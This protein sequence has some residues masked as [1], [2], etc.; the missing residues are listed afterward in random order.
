MEGWIKLHRQLL[1][2]PLWSCEVFSRGQAWV[3]L[4]MLANFERSFFYK[5]GVKIEVD[6]GQV[7]RSEV[8]LA[9]R[10]R[11][12]RTKVRSFL[13]DLEKEQ[14]I[15]QQKTN[16]TQIVE[17]INYEYYQQEKQQTGQQKNS[18]KT[19]ERQQAGQQTGQQTGQQKNSIRIAEYQQIGHQA[20]QKKNS[21]L[22]SKATSDYITEGQKKNTLKEEEEEKEIKEIIY[23]S[24]YDSEIEKSKSDS[25]YIRVVKILFGENNLGIPLESVLKM[26]IQLSYGQFKK[27]WYLKEKYKISIT[28]ILESMENWN[29]L[30]KRK[31]VYSTFLTFAKKR[32]PEITIK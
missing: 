25:N 1:D 18:R 7:A 30:K 21:R 13:N 29:D 32:N 16:I 20:G 12:S 19:A 23:N 17:I 15:I 9:D 31:T 2:N 8:E 10:W 6:R 28:E 24:F 11:W 27:I 22:D 26:P 3:D 5:R 14:Q 4:L